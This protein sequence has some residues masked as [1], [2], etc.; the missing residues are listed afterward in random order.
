MPSVRTIRQAWDEALYGPAGR[1]TTGHRDFATALTDPVTSPLLCAHL[2]SLAAHTAAEIG[3]PFTVVDVGAGTGTFLHHVA[4][5]GPADWRLTA[6]ERAPRPVGLDPRIVW[7]R[8]I[9]HRFQGFLLAHE[10]LDDIPLDVVRDGHVVLADGRR[11]PESTTGW[12]DRWGGT[13]DGSSRDDAWRD[14]VAHLTRGRALAVDYG[15]TRGDRRPTLT[16]WRGGRPVPPVFDG[17]CDLTAHVALDSLAAAVPGST[18]TTQRDALADLAP[19]D[20]PEISALRAL[21]D[22]DGYGGYGWVEVVLT[23]GS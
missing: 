6:V 18:L 23:S 8:E 13:E 17:S 4:E 3:D 14:A 16:G 5:R 9:P 2:L 21:R 7:Q 20:L 15:H 1:F 10:W 12:V 11:G 22:P 19:R